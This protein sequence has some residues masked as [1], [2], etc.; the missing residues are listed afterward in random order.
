[1]TAEAGGFVEV[2]AEDVLQPVDGAAGAAGE[3]EDEVVACE[4]TGLGT[5]EGAL[6]GAQ[7]EGRGWGLM[8]TYGDAGYNRMKVP[9]ARMK[10]EIW[11][12]E[13]EKRVLTDFLVSSRKACTLSKI[14]AM[15]RLWSCRP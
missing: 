13:W 11:I 10:M 4:L 9:V 8:R 1:M 3:R 15:S 5:G 6:A 7:G 12:W 14:C 2:E